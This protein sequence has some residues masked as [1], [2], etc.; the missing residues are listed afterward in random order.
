[1]A[2]RVDT[3]WGVADHIEEIA[4]GIVS[5]STPS[6]GGYWLS[7]E[8]IA[9]MPKPLR[10]FQPWAGPGYY[11]EDCDWSIV[12]LAFPQYFPDDAIPHALKTLE[13]YKP[14]V[15]EA[16]VRPADGVTAVKIEGQ[17]EERVR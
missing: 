17:G 4:P 13:R 11:E 1:M 14:E 16:F 5:Y 10:E 3:P 7:P 12:C 8:R 9:E 2:P 6:H 15:Y